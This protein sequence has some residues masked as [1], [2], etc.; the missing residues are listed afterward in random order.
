MASKL[1]RG[2]T[3][4]V[5][6]GDHSGASG[7]ILRID[8]ASGRAIVEGVNVIKRATRPSQQ[9]PGGGFVEREAT[10]HV[11]NIAAIDPDSKAPARVGFDKSGDRKIRVARGSGK[12]VEA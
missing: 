8:K 1:K 7:K 12:S 9:N 6:S 2:M 11:S 4:T 3:V 10:I 5:I